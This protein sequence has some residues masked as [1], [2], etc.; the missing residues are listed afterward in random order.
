MR[1]QYNAIAVLRAKPTGG[2][3]QRL[4]HANVKRINS[5]SS[6]YSP[7][8]SVEGFLTALHGTLK[9]LLFCVDADVD[10]QA[11]GC[12]EGF[13]AALLVAHECVFT[14][15]SLLMRA[16]VS[17]R[18]VGARTALEHA[19]VSLHLRDRKSQW[20]QREIGNGSLKRR[21]KG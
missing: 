3:E 17:R 15:V 11:V 8:E 6:S 4:K 19:L 9:G 21:T 7:V 20:S 1:P 13:A 14:A 10:L 18:A 16:Q 2:Q 12:E 5:V